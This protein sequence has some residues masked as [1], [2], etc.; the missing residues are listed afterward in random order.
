MFMRCL[1]VQHRAF[2]ITAL[3]HTRSMTE[4]ATSESGRTTKCMATGLTHGLMEKNLSENS[5]RKKYVW[6]SVFCVG[7][8]AGNFLKR[9]VV[10]GV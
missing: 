10:R 7:Q 3:L 4:I 1:R 8:I 5:G 9:R 6:S 2:S